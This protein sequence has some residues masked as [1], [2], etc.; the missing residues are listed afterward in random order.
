[1]LSIDDRLAL[2]ERLHCK[3]FKWYLDTVYPELTV[4]EARTKGSLSQGAY[5]ID[6]LGHLIDGTVGK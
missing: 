4:P 6:T 2:K 3:P 5:C 1:M